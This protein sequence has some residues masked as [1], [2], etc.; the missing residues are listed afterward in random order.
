[1]VI[2]KLFNKVLIIGLGLIGSSVARALRDY[3]L[4]NQIVGFDISSKVKEK[5]KELKIVD[6]FIDWFTCLLI[7]LLMICLLIINLWN[8]LMIF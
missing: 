4:T 3:E 2:Q 6:L 5:C 7:C 1:M 8:R